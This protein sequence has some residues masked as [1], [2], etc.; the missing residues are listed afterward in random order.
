[1]KI[2]TVDQALEATQIT[3][4][5][6]KRIAYGIKNFTFDT[7]PT[8]EQAAKLSDLRAR[9]AALET[10]QPR[11]QELPPMETDPYCNEYAWS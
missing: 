5:D 8:A 4:D 10:K 2:N 11:R 1:M 9:L 6:V 7:V 3:D